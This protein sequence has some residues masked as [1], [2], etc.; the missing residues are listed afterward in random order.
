MELTNERL[1]ILRN[2]IMYV[3][4]VWA[5]IDSNDCGYDAPISILI[6]GCISLGFGILL[7]LIKT[8]GKLLFLNN[9]TFKLRRGNKIYD[10]DVEAILSKSRKQ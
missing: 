3:Q 2:L 4:P 9:I 1:Q 10:K 8:S 5:Y 6:I 7:I